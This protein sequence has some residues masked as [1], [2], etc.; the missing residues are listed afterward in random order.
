MTEVSHVLAYYGDSV[1]LISM[2][3]GLLLIMS[4]I[5][6]YGFGTERTY[7][8]YSYLTQNYD[9]N[10]TINGTYAKLID[11]L[12]LSAVIPGESSEAYIKF[13]LTNNNASEASISVDIF[14]EDTTPAAQTLG[15]GNT[16]ILTFNV[17]DETVF[18]IQDDI[19]VYVFS[20]V[21]NV[22]INSL[23]LH[24]P[25]EKIDVAFEWFMQS[26]MLALVVMF[27]LY[28]VY[29]LIKQVKNA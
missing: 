2:V 18:T 21:D 4:L 19:S 26:V 8:G 17:P 24:Y 10:E 27:L 1:K 29:S 14:L 7:M 6:F 28:I 9:I 16:E 13:N 22:L 11:I 20:D 25:Y 5:T 23:E 3:L 15:A 12:S